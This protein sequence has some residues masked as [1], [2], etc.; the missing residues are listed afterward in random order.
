MSNLEKI[1]QHFPKAVLGTHSFR[2]DDTVIVKKEF[3]YE[4]L[5]YL[6][7][8]MELDFNM[9][10]DLCGVDYLWMESR[11]H[12][13]PAGQSVIPQ[14]Q[15]AAAKSESK[16]RFE[17]VY[18][19]YSLNKKHRIRVKASVDESDLTV[20]SVVSIWPAAN[21]FEREV[22][23]MFGI[24]FQGHPDMKRILMYEEFV[25]HPLRKDYPVNKRQPL[26]GPKN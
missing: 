17:V 7:S 4:V 24:K 22:W 20:E 21:W 8:D 19:L 2:G 25:G 15:P 3:I 18:H 1:A 23:D 12:F 5:Y 9:L 16:S 26:I 13:V 10:M 14:S 6:K 11:P